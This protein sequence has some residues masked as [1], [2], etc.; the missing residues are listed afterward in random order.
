[1]MRLGR[2]LVVGALGVLT[3]LVIGWLIVAGLSRWT[4]PREQTPA[5]VGGKPITEDAERRIRAKLF[6]VAEDGQRLVT[7]DR[8][9]PFAEAT[10]D[11]ARRLLEAELAAPRPPLTSAIPAGTK[12]RQVYVTDRGE[13]YVDLSS[14]LIS[15]HPGGSLNE[16]FTVHAIVNVLT[17][18]LPAIT[19]VQIL[20]EGKEVETLAGHVD[21][22][23]P[24]RP[25]EK[26]R[27]IFSR[28]DE[29]R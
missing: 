1:M 16:L 5:A 9:V 18:N 7:V 29:K 26:T 14:Q 27:V 10:A 17:A 13:A 11:Q 4:E 20:V 8:E 23:R 12:L 19:A 28:K 22:R 15:A 6:Y 25:S 21:V 3:A 24:L 2:P